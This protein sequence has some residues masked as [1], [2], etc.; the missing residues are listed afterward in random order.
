MPESSPADAAENPESTEAAPRHKL[1]DVHLDLTLN[2][3][4]VTGKLDQLDERFAKT[5]ALAE[6]VAGIVTLGDLAA[7]INAASS[8]LG[9]L[10]GVD[11]WAD[12]A[13]RQRAVQATLAMVERAEHLAR[14]K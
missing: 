5:L 11:S 14:G 9:V 4:D 8:V 1:G 6:R 2:A 3:S 7:A 10:T 13:T 12:A